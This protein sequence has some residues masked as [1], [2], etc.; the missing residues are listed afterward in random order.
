MFVRETQRLVLR[1]FQRGDADFL[2][3]LLNEPSFLAHMEDKGVRTRCQATVYIE[4]TLCTSYRAHGFGFCL[5]ARRDN[6]QPIGMCGLVRRD[7]GPEVDLGYAFLPEWWGRGYALEA[8]RAVLD[9][10]Q[11]FL[12]LGAVFALVRPDNARSI[13]LLGRLGFAF[14]QALPRDPGPGSVHLY[15]LNL[16]ERSRLARTGSED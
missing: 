10:A 7:S 14:A 2:L 16:A 8:A 15:A 12:G 13:A 3:R 1:P 4:R 5:V 6:G 9:W 11:G